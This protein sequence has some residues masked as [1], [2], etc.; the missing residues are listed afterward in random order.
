MVWL[1]QDQD[2]DPNYSI[3]SSSNH[4]VIWGRTTRIIAVKYQ[5]MSVEHWST[6]NRQPATPL[7]CVNHVNS[8]SLFCSLKLSLPRK[9]TLV[10]LLVMS[11]RQMS[12][13]STST[14]QIM[15]RS[16]YLSCLCTPSPDSI[17]YK[18]VSRHRVQ[19]PSRRYIYTM[20]VNL[21]WI[22]L[23]CTPWESICGCSGSLWILKKGRWI[24][25]DKIWQ[26]DV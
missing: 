11:E 20:I 14:R 16:A 21:V 4:N 13:L 15:K 7:Q 25:I 5:K 6:G 26:S 12:N 19:S 18:I 8:P 23:P 17:I 10:Y 22:S 9:R 24:Y 2:R 3:N 1:V